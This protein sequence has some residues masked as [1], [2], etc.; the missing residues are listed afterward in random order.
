MYKA[1]RMF[2]YKDG[3]GL[4][5]EALKGVCEVEEPRTI[6]SSIA[7]TPTPSWASSSR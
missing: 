5:Q 2:N 6:S 3:L 7:R 1:V 4:E